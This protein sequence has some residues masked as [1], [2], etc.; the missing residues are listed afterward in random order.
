MVGDYRIDL[1]AL[2]TDGDGYISRREARANE[3]LSAEFNAVDANRD[4]RLSR[5]ELSG[6][7]R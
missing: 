6:W 5:A 2:D 7:L 3:N 4:G 1:D